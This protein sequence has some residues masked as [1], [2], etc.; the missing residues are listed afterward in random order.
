M[1][2]SFH[3]FWDGTLIQPY[4]NSN[5]LDNFGLKVDFSFV[6]LFLGKTPIGPVD[7][8]NYLYKVLLAVTK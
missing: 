8:N 3:K 2:D 7:Q 1:A 6:I 5:N 4:W